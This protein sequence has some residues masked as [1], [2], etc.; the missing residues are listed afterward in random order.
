MFLS[1]PFSITSSRQQEDLKL[2]TTAIHVP[3]IPSFEHIIELY[4]IQSLF[5][6]RLDG[7]KS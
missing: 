4:N 3:R 7:T 5:S 6:S 2:A 1:P